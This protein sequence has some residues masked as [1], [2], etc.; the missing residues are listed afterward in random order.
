ML[1]THQNPWSLNSIGAFAGKLMLQDGG[2][3]KKTKE[4]IS[5]ERERLCRELSKL[6]AFKAYPP[7]ANFILLRILKDGVTS[8]QVFEAAIRQKM[9]IRDCSSFFKNLNGEFVRFC[10]MKPEDNERLL[11]VFRSI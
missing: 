11:K 4:L 1:L 10:I 8:F 9:M 7:S 2:Y 6:D 5:S 3:I